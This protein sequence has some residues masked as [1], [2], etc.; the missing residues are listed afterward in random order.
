MDAAYMVTV[1]FFC[2]DTPYLAKNPVFVFMDDEF[3]RP[4]PFTPDVVVDIDDVLEKKLAAVDALESQFYEG[5]C[6]GGPHL[7]P[8]PKDAAAVAA[9]KKQVR[10]EFFS[11]PYYS[12]TANRF[13]AVLARDYG[14][15]HAQKV[16]QAEAFEICEYGRKPEQ[17]E[18]KKLFPFF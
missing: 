14:Q 2:P 15:E 5:G 16:R 4:N 13:R 12:Q 11:Y 6:N 10:E 3:Q 1:P 7:V 8:D 18:L 9:R 17:D